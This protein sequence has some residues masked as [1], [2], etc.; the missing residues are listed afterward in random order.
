MPSNRPTHSALKRFALVLFVSSALP[1]CGPPPAPQNT[2]VTITTTP[3]ATPSAS[4]E[5]SA[6]DAHFDG[7]ASLGRLLEIGL[8]TIGKKAPPRMALEFGK[9]SVGDAR[10]V[11]EKALPEAD[12]KKGKGLGDTHLYLQA[13]LDSWFMVL[14]FGNEQDAYRNRLYCAQFTIYKPQGRTPPRASKV[15]RSIVSVRGE[16]SAVDKF[17][18]SADSVADDLE[19]YVWDDP[20]T[21]INFRSFHDNDDDKDITVVNFCDAKFYHTH[22]YWD[23]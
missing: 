2:T 6:G 7:A 20:G 21:V 8:S 13:D 11:L 23:Y 22:A 1:A 4:A 12:V 16:P 10:E 19:M 5:A 18:Y 14:R 17:H 9:T 15:F 3:T